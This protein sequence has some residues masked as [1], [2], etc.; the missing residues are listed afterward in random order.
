MVKFVK[1]EWNSGSIEVTGRN[2]TRFKNTIQSFIDLAESVNTMN[3]GRST[4]TSRETVNDPQL[5]YYE[6]E[7]PYLKE[8]SDFYTQ[9]S[10]IFLNNSQN[11]VATYIHKLHGWLTLEE[12][13]V[14][15]WMHQSSSRKVTEVL[16][17]VLIVSAHEF[18]S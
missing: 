17:D 7:T 9:E 6:V 18:E 3:S 10:T 14:T 5:Y 2:A 1:E 12:D 11:D 16:N 4:L 15:R 8:L 13:R